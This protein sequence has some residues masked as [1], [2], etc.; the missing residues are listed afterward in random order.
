MMIVR[1]QIVNTRK[2]MI[3]IPPRHHTAVK[4]WMILLMN[5]GK[6]IPE[7]GGKSQQAWNWI[8]HQPHA[9]KYGRTNPHMTCSVKRCNNLLVEA[10]IF[11]IL[12][13]SFCVTQNSFNFTETKKT[14]TQGHSPASILFP[15]CHPF[16]KLMELLVPFALHNF[17]SHCD[18]FIVIFDSWWIKNIFYTN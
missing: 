6:K 7:K 15:I 8:Y 3:R 12:G 13:V 9:F 18:S 10:D 2:I 1:L 5:F 4:I 14:G 11:S 16:L 17:F